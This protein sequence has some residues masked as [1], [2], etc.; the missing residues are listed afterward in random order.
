MMIDHEEKL[1]HLTAE[2]EK[3]RERIGELTRRSDEAARRC[4]SLKEEVGLLHDIIDN[5]PNC[6]IFVKD[7]DSRFIVTNDYQVRL[8]GKESPSDL[9]GKTDFDLFPKE[10]AE[11]FYRD[12]QE[13]ITTGKPLLNREEKTMDSKG[14]EY[15]LLT[16]KVPLFSRQRESTGIAGETAAVRPAADII[17]IVGVSR[18]ITSI[19]NL[20]AEREELIAKLQKALE[21]IHTLHGLIPICCSCKKVRDD[22]GYWQQVEVYVRDHSQAEFSHGYCPECMA[23][24]RNEIRRESDEHRRPK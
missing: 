6:H 21:K 1:Q 18:D 20:E 16:A 19:K 3:A 2:L 7:R 8:L 5:I 14:R 11:K 12:E 22:K 17:G 4:A 15:W 9:V 23:K 10:L 13:I 24:A